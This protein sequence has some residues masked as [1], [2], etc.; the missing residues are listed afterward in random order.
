M[1]FHGIACASNFLYAAGFLRHVPPSDCKLMLCDALARSMASALGFGQ[2]YGSTPSMADS[3]QRGGIAF[4]PGGEE[5]DLEGR[6]PSVSAQPS[7][8]HSP[9]L[10]QQ[11]DGPA[12][13]HVGQV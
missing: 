13:V 1:H 11:R 10:S 7:A 4:E 6:S 8:L 12:N 2:Q 5:R 9:R 3:S